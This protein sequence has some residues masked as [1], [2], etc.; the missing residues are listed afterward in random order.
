VCDVK[1]REPRHGRCLACYLEW[2]ET[3]SVGLGAAC[4]VCGDRRR[5]HLRL[6][7]LW[8]RSHALCCNCA[9][10]SLRLSPMPR[11]AAALRAELARDRRRM[12]DRRVGLRDR[13]DLPI[14]RRDGERR[15]LGDYGA[16]EVEFAEDEAVFLDDAD[17]VWIED[18]VDGA[19]AFADESTQI[20][21]LT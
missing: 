1:T 20:R 16:V 4:L 10:R 17:I 14:D 11:G 9:A 5:D 3:R 2:C 6:V 13:R 8:G 12:P 19:D 18:E 7:E 21:M 15:R